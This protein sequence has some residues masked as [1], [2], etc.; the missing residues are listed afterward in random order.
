M[1]KIFFLFSVIEHCYKKN[2]LYEIKNY[3]NSRILITEYHE[4]S[5]LLKFITALQNT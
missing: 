4:K 5:F 2:K 1:K 3:T